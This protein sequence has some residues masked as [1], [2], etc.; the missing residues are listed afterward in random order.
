MKQ[1]F[2]AELVQLEE[3][4]KQ[5]RE[6]VQAETKK[7]R[8]ELKEKHEAELAALRSDHEKERVILE[9][10][11]HAE[12]EK[13]KSLQLSLNDDESKML[14]ETFIWIVRATYSSHQKFLKINMF[15]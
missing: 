9:R 10:A 2:S 1:E 5:E 12:Q 3:A 11:L 7:M 15:N 14:F 6:S 4:L 13:L 8:E